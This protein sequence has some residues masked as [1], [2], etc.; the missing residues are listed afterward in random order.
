MGPVSLTDYHTVFDSLELV[1]Q[2]VR[3]T[4]PITRDLYT[5]WRKIGYIEYGNN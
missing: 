1:I 3:L 5:E 4:E 2:R